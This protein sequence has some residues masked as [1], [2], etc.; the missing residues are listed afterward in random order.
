MDPSTIPLLSF[1]ELSPYFLGTHVH[2]VI[3]GINILANSKTAMHR[4][5]LHA[6]HSNLARSAIKALPIL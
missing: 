2:L 6:N 5:T 1:S 3:I 4:W